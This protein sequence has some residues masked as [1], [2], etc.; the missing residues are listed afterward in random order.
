VF[1]TASPEDGNR[2]IFRNAVFFRIPDDGQTSTPGNPECY[3]PS[4]ESFRLYLYPSDFPINIFWEFFVYH[5]S[6]SSLS[7]LECSIGFSCLKSPVEN[8]RIQ[9]AVETDVP[10]GGKCPDWALF[11]FFCLGVFNCLHKRQRG[12]YASNTRRSKVN[13]TSL[14]LTL[15]NLGYK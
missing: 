4:S 1:P 3:T 6:A 14:F 2:S 9:L 12:Y 15:L 10:R 8:S 5:K 11:R 7:S 13:L